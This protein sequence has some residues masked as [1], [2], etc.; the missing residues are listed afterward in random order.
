MARL[1]FFTTRCKQHLLF[2]SLKKGAWERERMNNWNQLS[3]PGKVTITDTLQNMQLETSAKPPPSLP[4]RH[5]SRPP[6]S[7]R[8]S[9]LLPTPSGWVLP[10][11]SPFSTMKFS[12]RLTEHAIWQSKPLTMQLPSLIHSAKS[13]TRIRPWSCNCWEITWPCG[14]RICKKVGA[15]LM[16]SI[17]KTCAHYQTLISCYFSNV[18]EGGDKAEKKAEEEA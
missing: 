2:A 5:T 7:L 1:K 14:L 3:K 9:L 16:M 6:K 8:V 18:A 12:T 17:S 4:T 15:R 13:P 10:S 11:T